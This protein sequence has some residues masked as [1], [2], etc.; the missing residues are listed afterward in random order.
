M[1]LIIERAVN[2]IRVLIIIIIS[3]SSKKPKTH[4][5]YVNIPQSRFFFY[6]VYLVKC[7]DHFGWERQLTIEKKIYIYILKWRKTFLVEYEKCLDLK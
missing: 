1:Q 6:L 2:W 7:F 5:V 4:S 3:I